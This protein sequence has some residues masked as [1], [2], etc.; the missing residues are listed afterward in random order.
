MRCSP[1]LVL[2][3]VVALGAT[4]AMAQS[5]TSHTF[6][7]MGKGNVWVY[8][9]FSYF[10][11][12]VSDTISA[13]TL[14]DTTILGRSYAVTR[15]LS[16]HYQNSTL[17]YE[18]TDSISDVY[19]FDTYSGAPLLLYR[20]SDTSRTVW[21]RGSV[22]VRFDSSSYRIVFG[23]R[24]HVLFVNLY[25]T[26]DS[27]FAHSTTQEQLAE[28]LGLIGVS[29]PE[30]SSRTLIGAM[31]NGTS[32]GLLNDIPVPSARVPVSFELLSNFPNP[33][34]PSTTITY[35]LP[36]SGLV[37]LKI[38]DLIG[39]EVSTLV[40]QLRTPG[41]YTVQWDG[42]GQPSGVYFCR[43]QSRGFVET[44]RMILVR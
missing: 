1:L 7:P 4:C 14:G 35:R 3:L 32:S 17:N 24:V 5:D 39:R 11:S 42:S 36:V 44:K 28:G 41:T 23:R 27:A 20:L 40:N 22:N 37:D 10:V 30:G 26:L 8:R 34:N 19:R 15:W 9:D 43:L 2:M 38:F 18:R 29:W 16:Q 12:E 31:I 6:Y 13:A 25:S 33:F 21:K